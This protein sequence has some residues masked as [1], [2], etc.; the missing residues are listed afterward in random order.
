MVGNLAREVN[1]TG[2]AGRK[3]EKRNSAGPRPVP[4]CCG[5]LARNVRT[6]TRGL[7]GNGTEPGANH[8]PP[9]ST[10][11]VATAILESAVP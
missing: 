3:V 10:G 9:Y 7:F 4:Q 1:G 6:I 11:R 2:W 8:L 5:P